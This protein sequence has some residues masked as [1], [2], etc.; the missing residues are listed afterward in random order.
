M[1]IASSIE[2]IFVTPS[3]HRVHHSTNDILDKNFGSTLI[4]DAIFGT[5]QAEEQTVSLTTP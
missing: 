1:K 2:Y 5:F 4:W 3:H